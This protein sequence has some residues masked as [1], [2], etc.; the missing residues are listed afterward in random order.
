[1]QLMSDRTPLYA[2]LGE[3]ER[4]A[5][6][7]R[8]M[9]GDDCPPQALHATTE[10]T[11]D[12]T[13]LPLVRLC[14]DHRHG[15]VLRRYVLAPVRPVASLAL[16]AKPPACSRPHPLPSDMNIDS[17][18]D[19]NGVKF[20]INLDAVTAATGALRLMPGSHREPMHSELSSWAAGEMLEDLPCHIC[21]AEPGDVIGY[22]Q[23]LWVPLISCAGQRSEKSLVHR[24]NMRCFHASFGGEDARRI[25]TVCIYG[26]RATP[27]RRRAGR[28]AQARCDHHRRPQASPTRRAVAI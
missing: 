24:F 26:N 17:H 21:E 16:P 11:G 28:R 18:E 8:Q 19:L 12:L 22:A 14:G 9:F 5:A 13:Q 20:Y 3:D 15:A 2:S 6:P 27:R 10:G 1:M 7:A 23:R 4:L 25:S